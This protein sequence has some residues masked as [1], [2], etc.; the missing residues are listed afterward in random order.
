MP[1]PYLTYPYDVI[2]FHIWQKQKLLE[3]GRRGCVC[4]DIPKINYLTTQPGMQQVTTKYCLWAL[5]FLYK[6]TVS[7][8]DRQSSFRLLMSSICCFFSFFLSFS[9]F[10]LFI[11]IVSTYNYF[12]SQQKTCVIS[13]SNMVAPRLFDCIIGRKV[14]F[15]HILFR[16]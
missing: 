6:R 7:N 13:L 9:C 14:L 10:G 5:Y 11:S 2:R 12:P 15:P 16:Q 3:K 1:L 4:P 8:K